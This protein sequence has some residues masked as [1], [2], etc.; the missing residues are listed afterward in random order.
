MSKLSDLG[1]RKLIDLLL[2]IYGKDVYSGLGDDAAVL[3]VGG[4]YLLLTTDVV[5]E[6]THIPRGARAEQVGWYAVAVNFS[7]IAAMGGEPVGFM[8]ALTMPRGMEGSYVEGLARGIA[9]CVREFDARVLG[10]DTKEGPE[11]SVSGVAIGWTKGKRVLRRTGC[12]PGDHVAV[13]GV[14]GRAGWAQ[15]NLDVEEHRRKAIEALMTPRPRV[16]EGL[17]LAAN[18]SVTACMDISDGLASSLDQLRQMN[19]LS[20]QIT[21]EDLPTSSLLDAASEDERKEAV[22]FQGGDFELLF[23]VRPEGWESLHSEMEKRGH[24]VTRVGI[25]L[26]GE[27]NLLSVRDDVEALEARGWEHFR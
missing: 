2:G 16:E 17:V 20:F 8:S 24:D 4:R 12:R 18:P 15:E 21:Y 23:T 27:K 9:A 25:V 3:P 22:L 11:L 13:T 7:D 5:N 26:E 10:G 1:E 19:G 6:G 14:L